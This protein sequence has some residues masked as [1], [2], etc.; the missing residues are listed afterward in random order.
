[1]HRVL[2]LTTRVLRDPDTLVE[3]NDSPAELARLAPPL[4]AIT[5]GAG[6]LFG[7]MVGSQ[8]GGVQLAYAAIKMPL[9]LLLPP[10]VTLPAVHALYQQSGV[11]VSWRRLSIAALAG[12][13]RSAILAAALGPVLWLLYS[14]DLDYHSAVLW[15]VGVL[16]VAGLPGIASLVR[17][18]PKGGH[19][20]A[21]AALGSGIVLFL[22]FAQ[23]GWLLRPFIARPTAE[24]TFLRPV[25]ENVFSS[26]GA[27]QRSAHGEYDGWDARATGLLNPEQAP[28]PTTPE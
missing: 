1:M 6:A 23:T 3:A 26:L 24:V 15:M 2:V 27:T 16:C 13:A 4:L 9:L 22:A 14:M 28:T 20:R 7:F 12:M 8:Y 17:S 25:E 21:L 19:H 5:I 10:L 11:D 18:L